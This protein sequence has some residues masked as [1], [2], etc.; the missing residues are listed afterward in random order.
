MHSD[1]LSN[2]DYSQLN[3]DEI[4]NIKEVEEKINENRTESVILLAVDHK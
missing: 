4:N 2:I 1:D 3:N